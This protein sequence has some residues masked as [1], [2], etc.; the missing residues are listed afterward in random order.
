VAAVILACEVQ[1]QQLLCRS[2]SLV[3]VTNRKLSGC[4]SESAVLRMM[5][6]EHVL[7]SHSLVHHSWEMYLM[8]GMEKYK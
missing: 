8:Q 5:Q 2:G 7:G 6:K 1:W 4:F 3:R